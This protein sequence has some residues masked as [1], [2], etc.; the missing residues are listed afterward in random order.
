MRRRDFVYRSSQA[1]MAVSLLGFAACKD[2]T[3]TGNSEA[4]DEKAI[5]TTMALPPFFKLSLGQY[6]LHRMIEAGKFDPYK[7]AEKAKNLGFIGLEY[8]SQ[9]YDEQQ[10]ATSF[11]D[12]AMQRFV[13]RSNAE[14][15][16]HGMKNLLI[17]I[18]EQGDLA[19]SDE[20]DRVAAVSNHYKWVDAAAATGCHSIRVNLD[21][22]N[23]PEAWISNSVDGLKRLATYARDKNIN[24]IVENHGGLSSNAK[25]LARVMQEVDMDNCGTLPDFG[26]FC[27]RENEAEECLEE[28]DRY[29]GVSELMPYAKAVS[30]KSH[31]FDTAG[32]ETRT[33]YVKM[34]RIVKDAGYTGFIGVEY[35]GDKIGEEDGIIATRDLLLKASKQMS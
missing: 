29:Q 33:D 23:T 4:I 9:F 32:N 25:L 6:S 14:A 17:M 30:A 21:G 28:Y 10:Q 1:G 27:I 8:V 2:R 34:L 5:E 13:E 12:D 15:E 18:D 31:D 35:E 19:T 26:N 22:S 20:N 16:K 3:K 7:F 24:V 11:S